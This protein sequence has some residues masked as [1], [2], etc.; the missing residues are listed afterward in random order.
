MKRSTGSH[1]ATLREASQIS[2]RRGACAN[3][4]IDSRT[5]N[6]TREQ[7][8][9]HKKSHMKSHMREEAHKREEPRTRRAAGGLTNAGEVAEEREG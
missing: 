1:R 8:Q 6:H 4:H 3:S 9:E 2:P 7:P 5:Y